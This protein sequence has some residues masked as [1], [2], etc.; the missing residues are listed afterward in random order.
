MRDYSTDGV[1]TPP[2]KQYTSPIDERWGGSTQKYD[3]KI[4][5]E[6]MNNQQ[7]IEDVRKL[8]FNLL[9]VE[10]QSSYEPSISTQPTSVTSSANSNSN[11]NTR[12]ADFFGPEVF[13]IVLHNPT[14]AHRLKKFAQSRLCGENLEFLDKVR[15]KSLSEVG[16]AKIYRLT[17]TTT[18]SI[19]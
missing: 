5:L 3:R 16:F 13:Q 4:S 10:E 1:F 15:T 9:P 18:Y 6:K 19:K 2:T 14:T 8:D 7:D 17:N 12:I 11:S